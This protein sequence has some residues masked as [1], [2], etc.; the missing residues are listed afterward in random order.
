MLEYKGIG[1]KERE[2]MD[3]RLY[4][5]QH[6]SLTGNL[7]GFFFYYF[8]ITK[9]GIIDRETP[10]SSSPSWETPSTVPFTFAVRRSTPIGCQQVEIMY[11]QYVDDTIIFC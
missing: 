3:E 2:E 10:V 4:F 7:E 5:I 1:K 9:E 11:L 8:V 6:F